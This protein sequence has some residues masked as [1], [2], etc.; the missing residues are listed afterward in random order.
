MLTV[1]IRTLKRT[2]LPLEDWEAL[3]AAL[4]VGA[5]TDEVIVGKFIL[6][7]P[8]EEALEL[9]DRIEPLIQNLCLYAPKQLLS[10]QSYRFQHWNYAASVVLEPDGDKVLVSGDLLKP[11]VI[12]KRELIEALLGCA[13][14][15]MT[16]MQHL[17]ARNPAYSLWAYPH[18]A[19][20]LDECT[21]LYKAAYHQVP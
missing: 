2:Y 6:A 16:L 7:Q 5:L 12:A 21:G 20:L 13:A 10:G 19:E 1:L 3:H 8:G 4:E 14:R 9:E 17:H 15:V 18:F 11:T